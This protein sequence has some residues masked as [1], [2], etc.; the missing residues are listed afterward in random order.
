MPTRKPPVRSSLL[1]VAA[2]AVALSLGGC[3]MIQETVYKIQLKII[4]ETVCEPD[5]ETAQWVLKRALE[6]AVVKN[7]EQGWE[8]FQNVLHSSEQSPNALRGWYTMGWKRLR[9]QAKDYLDDDGCFKIVDFKKVMSSR[10]ELAGIDY[11]I[12]SRKKEMPTPCAVY[13]DKKKGDK[14]RIKRCSL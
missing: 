11:Y 8:R 9:R 10:D 14:W 13:I 2:L 4:G 12:Q 7:Q 5:R 1:P 3:E 6:A